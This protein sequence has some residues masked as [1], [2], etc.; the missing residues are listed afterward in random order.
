MRWLLHS[1]WLL[2]A[3][4]GGDT[5]T[6]PLLA[7]GQFADGQA[8]ANTGEARSSPILTAHRV[9]HPEGPAPGPPVAH[10][11]SA[12][13]DPD[14]AVREDAIEALGDRGDPEGISGLQRA[15]YSEYDWLK[16]SAIEAL[17]DIGT[18]EAV[19]ALGPLLS[20][21]DA[22]LREAVVDALA[23]IGTDAARGYLDQALSDSDTNVSAMASE[24]LAELFGD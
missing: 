18:D 11:V 7:A 19:M 2:Q 17:A 14:P 23:D 20:D 8:S 13:D 21:D 5:S 12:L 16:L 3:I 4:C 22:R 1:V 10:L 9:D 6:P 24:A 15:L